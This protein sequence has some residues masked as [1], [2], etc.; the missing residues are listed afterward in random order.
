MNQLLCYTLLFA[1]VLWVQA[2]QAQQPLY[3]F[4]QLPTEIGLTHGIINCFWQDHRGFLWFGTW[5]GLGRYD[6]YEVK[7]YRP[8]S[9]HNNGLHSD[10]IT[11][12]VEDQ[13]QQLWIGTVNA[14][15]Y[16]FDREKELF[17]NFRH[18]PT[19]ANS[20]SNN[21]VWSLFA[22][23]KGF[24]WV[25]TEKGINRFDPRTNTFLN[26][27]V[28][29]NVKNGHA[30]DYI[31]SICE[32][33]DGSIWYTTNRGLN[34]IKFETAYRYHLEHYQLNTPL[35]NGFSL[36]DFIY[37]VRP[38]KNLKNTIWL[39]TKA[40]LKKVTYHT[41]DLNS[42]QIKS[43]SANPADPQGLSHNV[44]SDIWEE[45]NGNVW[46]GTFNGLNLFDPKTEK[47]RRFVSQPYEAYSL[48]NNWV[49]ELYQDHSGILWI[50]TG[51][52]IN[53][54]NLRNKP[55]HSIRLERGARSTNSTVTAF[56]QGNQHN[57]IWVGTNGGLNKLYFDGHNNNVQHYTLAPKYL[58]DF[59]NF[60]TGVSL[61]SDG[62]IWI[63][64]QGAGVLR[65]REK[66]IPS[67]GG[68]LTHLE[69]FTK[70]K[71]N[72][73]YVIYMHDA[74]S[75]RIWFGL[76]DGGIDLYNKKT[77]VVHHFQTVDEISLT[78]FP[79]V[80][81]IESKEGNNI[82]LWVGTRG[83]GVMKLSYDVY[84]NK[85]HLEKHYK[86]NANKKGALSNDKINSLFL[87]SQQR[88]WVSTGEGLS[89]LN[90]QTNNFHTFTQNDGLPDNTIQT[91]L[92]DAQ[93]TIWVSTTNGIANMKWQNGKWQIRNYDVLDGLQD[94]FFNNNCGLRMPSGLLSFG[95]VEGLNIFAPKQICIDSTPPMTAF[96]DFMLF[97]K[98]VPIGKM[99]NGRTILNNYI[100][101]TNHIIL[102]HRENVLSFEFASLHFAEP[103]KNKFAY[104]LEGFDPDWVYTDSEKRYAHYTNLPYR[105]FIFKVKSA[106]GDGI[107]S[108]PIS[109]RVTIKPPF[110][111]TWWAFTVYAAL[112][113]ALLYVGWWVT[114]MRATFRSRL[115][116]EQI[117]REKL[118][119]VNQVK[120]QFFTNIS[121]ELRTPLTLIISPLEQ[122]VREKSNDRALLRV[123]S[124]MH[125]NAGKLLT[126]INQLLDFRK[127][128]A[129]L[130]KIRA[131][132]TN[133]TFFIKEIILSFKAFAREHQIELKFYSENEEIV[134]W[135]DRDQ[136]EKAMFNLLSNAFKFTP[137]GG[138]VEVKILENIEKEQVII[139][140]SD[141]G[142]GIESAQLDKIFAPFHQGDNQPQQ[143]IF[144]GTGIG[145]ALVKTIMDQHHGEVNVASEP[146]NGAIFSLVLRTGYA[147]FKP[148]E[149]AAE[150][151]KS[152]FAEQFVLH[153]S[154]EAVVHEDDQDAH[155]QQTKPH[156]LIVEDNADIRIYLKENLR[157]DYDVTEAADGIEALEKAR[158]TPPDLILSDITMPRMDGIEFCRH[159]KRDI[160][161]SHIPVVLLTARTSMVYK[162]DGLETGADDY[163]T[164][165][166]SMQLL[167]VRIK[168]LI[169]IRTTLREKFGKTF[170]LAP[171]AVTVTSLD[172]EFLQHILDIVEQH[173]DD[174]DFS[175]DCLAKK[176][177]MS[178]MQ[179]YRKVKALTNEAPNT[180]IRTIRLKRA[181]QLLA[182]H[183]YNI[184]EVAYKVGFSD[185]KYFRERFK[186]QFG[187][188][189]SA[190]N[191]Q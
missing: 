14:G 70:G 169:H 104:K 20:L 146:G 122:L 183:Q 65:V 34:R 99:Q 103:K 118:E 30:A 108:K 172:E 190:Y 127:S 89:V 83:N 96:S 46:I 137:D 149:I 86:Y 29:D 151:I 8:K 7:I 59:A 97:N 119:E 139:L 19:N 58:A 85:L 24:I 153:E 55:F 155:S 77:G 25:G 133:L 60:T 39:G 170:D 181:A 147:H 43:Y 173:L 174:N 50:G 101:E 187:V 63:S 16:R 178:R 121:H 75:N 84:N 106:N 3:L 21:D 140:V 142:Q 87:D 112:F 126:M 71:L 53:K 162:I 73:D 18:D 179:L 102:N 100:T 92:E 98:S 159:I 160:L 67:K 57:Q 23:S 54:L 6:G 31:Y 161:T 185:L 115:A 91:V 143:A 4:E 166:F 5:S 26:I 135:I 78:A 163:I 109:L 144:S 175:I 134:A 154:S 66:D 189:P 124:M 69:Q 88:L 131:E 32:T 125:Q 113:V 117:E 2:L 13:N 136:I 22:D 164:K 47:F 130:M 9:G 182:T 191:S 152:A 45:D 42:L 176:M 38:S 148:E 40:G 61:D 168:N 156:L 184:S 138:I 27:L 158:E 74:G 128:E 150:P 10:Q 49:Y 51:K 141:S 116:L 33:P 171:S 12:I 41:T 72:D 145:L 120:L 44:I 110:W 111:L 48:S 68:K 129:G 76:W 114:H 180:L 132:K 80:N 157:T 56:C 1:Q 188:I 107:W 165:P 11:A 62:W 52:G 105:D 37:K 17:I 186:E 36:D 94:N 90:A 35:P 123:L 167:K 95:G 177:T 82:I 28:L 64:T 79:N 93:G 81:I 15:F